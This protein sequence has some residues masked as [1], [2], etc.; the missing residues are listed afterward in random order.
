MSATVAWDDEVWP[1]LPTL[2][3][4]VS[5]DL[6][7]VGL[8]GSGLAAVAAARA[9][10]A[11]VVGLDA[12][13]VGS[14]AA[15]RNGGFLLAGAADPHHATVARLGRTP[16]AAL[17]RAT[18]LE[19]ARMAAETPAA[20]RLGGSV[21]LATDDDE[22][23]DC[24]AQR[25]AME[26]DGLAVL[27]YSG[28]EGDGLVFPSDGSL[29]PLA[30]CRILGR[31]AL[32]S[33]ARLFE[34][35]PAVSITTGRVRTP[36]GEVRCAAVLVA[37]D[38]GL[39]VVLPELSGRVRTARLQMLATA[40]TDEV[41]IPRPVYARWGYDYWQQLPSG[42][43]VVGGLR[44]RF[45]DDE[46]DAPAEPSDAVQAGLDGLLRRQIGVRQAPI[47]QRWAGR[48]G[49]TPDLSP[50]DE[51]VRPRVWAIGGYCGTGNV[52]GSLLGRAAANRLLA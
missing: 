1:P 37:V 16:A 30:R 50:I 13:S 18:L 34:R 41:S 28:P 11:Q 19:I 2:A 9:S 52:L 26:A 45:L 21:R 36:G 47:V 6:C 15:G 49:Y 40:P 7:V 29:Q 35:S 46:W 27:P 44:D 3:G 24:S 42:A 22:V 14:G 51:E 4:T 10:G 20:I 38:G 39:E 23:E 8:G 31:T 17:Y 48:V 25:R 33:G 43:V 5:A 12:A 32:A